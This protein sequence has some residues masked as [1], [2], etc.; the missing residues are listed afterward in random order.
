V[1]RLGRAAS[2]SWNGLRPIARSEE[3]FR[4]ELFVFIISVPLAF[5]IATE[6]WKRMVLVLVIVFV[7]IV[8]LLN[9]RSRS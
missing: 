2:N 8:E 1:Y 7:M 9:P 5:V 4:Q 3:A 6:T